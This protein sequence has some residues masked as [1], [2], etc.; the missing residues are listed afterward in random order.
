VLL[1]HITLAIR[2]EKSKNSK[3]FEKSESGG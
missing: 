3:N 2:V 1:A